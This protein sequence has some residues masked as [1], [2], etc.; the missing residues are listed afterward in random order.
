METAARRRLGDIFVERG[1]ITDEQLKEA[2]AKQ[3]ETGGKLGETL[4]DLGFVDRVGLAG[5]ITEQWDDLRVTERGRKTAQRRPV[6]DT[7]V[8]ALTQALAE[9]DRRIAQQDATI[10]ALIAQLGSAA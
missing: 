9:R 10:T 3:S 1:L 8:E 4:V 7:Q 2:L 5:V 6:Q